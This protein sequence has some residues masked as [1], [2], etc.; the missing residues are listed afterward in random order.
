MNR[1]STSIIFA[2]VTGTGPLARRMPGS[3]ATS[4]RR[5]GGQVFGGRHC[6][7]ISVFAKVCVPE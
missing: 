2:N 4:I 3:E 6:C 5:D 1:G 7:S